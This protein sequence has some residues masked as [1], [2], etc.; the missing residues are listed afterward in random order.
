[1]STAAK[2]TGVTA[3]LGPIV[4][5]SAAGAIGA[6]E[7]ADVQAKAATRAEEL[8]AQAAEQA[9]EFQR[10]RFEES[11]ELLSPFVSGGVPAF[12]RQQALSGAL[13]P[14]AQREAF[15]QFEESPGVSFLREQGQ[16]GIERQLSATGGL[17]GA[18]RLKAISEFNQG[19]ALQDFQNQFNRLGALTGVGLGAAQ[20]LSGAGQQVGAGQAQTVLGSAQARGQALQ[21]GGAARAAGITG[22]TQSFQSGL[23]DLSRLGGFVAGGGFG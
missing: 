22:I 17:G 9:L 14:E 18:S 23:E 13:G 7:A 4:G 3:L 2:M 16:R 8:R 10:E 12:Q 19:L 6:Q 11:K 21:A 5:G 15:Q 20:A 1:M